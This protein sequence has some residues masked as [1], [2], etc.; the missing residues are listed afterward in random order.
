MFKSIFFLTFA[1][2]LTSFIGYFIIFNGDA[3]QQQEV[4]IS[5]QEY[6]LGNFISE[7]PEINKK[8]PYKIDDYTT[9]NSI[10]YEDSKVLSTYKLTNY[11]ASSGEFD[12]FIKEIE[13]ILQKKTCTDEVKNKLLDVGIEFLDVYQDSEGS[14]IL[15]V[16]SNSNLCKKLIQ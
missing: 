8:L 1:A 7:L 3:E 14:A 16:L 13:P 10:K 5:L 9:L 15:K 2:I 12:K 11:N 4:T 6:L